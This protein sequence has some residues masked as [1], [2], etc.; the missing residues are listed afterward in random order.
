[1]IFVAV[2]T[3]WKWKN[4]NN[5]DAISFDATTNS[6]DKI[7]EYNNDNDDTANE[8]LDIIKSNNNNVNETK[9]EVR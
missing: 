2:I 1:M 4:R 7:D 9:D 3:H 6:I 8:Y 5:N